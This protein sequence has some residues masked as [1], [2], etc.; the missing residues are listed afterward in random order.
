MVASRVRQRDRAA[1][2]HWRRALRQDRR[3]QIY[4]PAFIFRAQPAPPAP[5]AAQASRKRNR[6]QNA[7]LSEP[8]RK[9]YCTNRY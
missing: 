6:F 8:I 7:L 5:T 4:A 3:N 9:E 1:H 2:I